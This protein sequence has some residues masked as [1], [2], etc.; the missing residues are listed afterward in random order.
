LI[1]GLIFGTFFLLNLFVWAKGSSG[2]VPFTTML[3][4]VL[5]WF[6]IS[7]PLSVAGSWLGFKQ[8][9]CSSSAS[10][11]HLLTCISGNRRSNEDQPNS[12]TSSS[13]D[14]KPSDNSFFATYGHLAV[15]RY[16]CGAVLH[17]DFLVDEQDLLHVRI[18]L[19]LLWT[20]DH[21]HCGHHGPVGLLFVVR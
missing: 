13:H 17:H 12:E 15:W 21:D 10:N 1:P 11:E 6:V 4:L 18:P 14:W 5:I 19:P 16:L 20:H 9:V 2:A 7:V 3:A 8:R